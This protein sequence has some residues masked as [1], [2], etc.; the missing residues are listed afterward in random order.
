MFTPINNYCV[1][2]KV[3]DTLY[4]TYLDANFGKKMEEIAK[5]EKRITF[6]KKY[7]NFIIYCTKDSFYC[8]DS[9]EHS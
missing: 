3:K 8:L 7:K 1:Y 5:H 6:I 2:Y 4:K 9:I